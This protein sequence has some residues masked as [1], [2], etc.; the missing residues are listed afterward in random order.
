MRSYLV[1][2]RRHL[3]ISIYSEDQKYRYL[4][5]RVFSKPIILLEKAIRKEFHGGDM[6]YLDTG[7]PPP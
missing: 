2:W 3:E 6:V 5:D 4:S 7:T 1:F